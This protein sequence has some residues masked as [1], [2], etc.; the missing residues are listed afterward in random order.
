MQK[1]PRART[2]N[3]VVQNLNDEVLL[4]DLTTNQAY[5][6]NAALGKV[7]NACDGKTAFSELENRGELT[8]PVIF[9]A[10]DTLRKR[11]LLTGD[12]VSPFAGISRLEFIRTAG[13]ASVAALP[14][15]SALIAPSAANAAS[16]CLPPNAPT[17]LPASC[18]PRA[19]QCFFETCRSACCSNTVRENINNNDGTVTCTCA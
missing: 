2:G 10:L 16:N 9:L 18:D 13:L 12:Y 1:L 19:G 14:V 6:L 3:I 4:Y 7:Y 8:E 11:N 15:L 5:C 17:V